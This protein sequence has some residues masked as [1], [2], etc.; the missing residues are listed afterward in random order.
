MK[1]KTRTYLNVDGGHDVEVTSY[2]DGS[3]KLR[4]GPR[5]TRLFP[6]SVKMLIQQLDVYPWS[7]RLTRRLHPSTWFFCPSCGIGL[8]ADQT[9][10]DK[11]CRAAS[12]IARRYMV[13]VVCHEGESS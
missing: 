1:P 8:P 13:D 10:H 6:Y 11:G 9:E 2:Q 7:L 5:S 4:L 3:A 12:W